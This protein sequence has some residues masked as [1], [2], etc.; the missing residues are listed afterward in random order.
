MFN[1]L[2]DLTE[3]GEYYVLRSEDG[4]DPDMLYVY[5]PST[6][7]SSSDIYLTTTSV[8]TINVDNE[9]HIIFEGIIFEGSRKDTVRIYQSTNR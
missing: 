1:S 3:P 8:G 2:E 9:K 4:I 7:D 6:I 5:P